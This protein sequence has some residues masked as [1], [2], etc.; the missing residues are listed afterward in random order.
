MFFDIQ[1]LEKRKIR[2]DHVFAPDSLNFR[3]AGLKQVGDLRAQGEAELV[4]PFGVRE[5]RIRGRLQG[6]VE[7]VCARCL[8]PV[9]VPVAA[10]LDLYYRPMAEIARE[11]EV[12]I[13]EAETEMGFYEGGGLELADVVQEQVIIGLPMRSVCREDCLG[14]CPICG[15]NRN[16]NAC[17]CREEMADPRWDALRSWK[18]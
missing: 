14:L 10:A 1:V 12:S 17:T 4:D 15:G 11:E 16:W 7:V 5:I 2:F 8:E 13:S 6:E 9:R 3:D 18:N